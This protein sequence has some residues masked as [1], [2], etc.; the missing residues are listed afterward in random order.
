MINTFIMNNFDNII[1]TMS[2]HNL[3]ASIKKIINNSNNYINKIEIS[4]SQ[5]ELINKK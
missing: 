1:S 4:K 2:G 5:K 3:L